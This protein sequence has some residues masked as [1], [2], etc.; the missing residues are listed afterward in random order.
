MSSIRVGSSFP[1]ISYLTTYFDDRYVNITGDTM[2]GSLLF[3]PSVDT[4][5]ILHVKNAAGDTALIVDLVNIGGDFPPY[6]AA[7]GIGTANPINT[8]LLTVSNVANPSVGAQANGMAVVI[9]GGGG[10]YVDDNAGGS[11]KYEVFGS[12]LGFGTTTNTDVYFY[13]N[14]TNRMTITG[15]GFGFGTDNTTPGA[16]LDV[17]GSAIFNETGLNVD[18]RVEGDT[19]ANLLF[20]DASADA[21]GIGTATPTNKLHVAGSGRFTGTYTEATTNSGVHVG[22]VGGTPRLGFFNS[23]AA[24]NWQIDNST[25]TFRWYL[26]GVVHMQLTSTV[27]TANQGM[28]VNETGGNNDI[29]MEGDTATSL[30][31][32]DADVDAVQIGTTVAGAIADFRNGTIVF[33][34]DGADRDI[35]FEGD[36]DV[37]TFYLDAGNNRIGFGT[38]T[39]SQKLHVIG[40]FQVD[41]AT[42]ST[43]G[44]RFRT[45]G[46]NLDVDAGGASLFLS[47]FTTA[48]FGGTQRTY[49]VLEASTENIQLIG[50]VQYR[51]TSF[52][53]VR[54][55]ISG[56]A[57][58]NVTFNEDGASADFRVEG[59]T[60]A[61]LLFVDG[62][63]DFVGIG[64]NA[65]TNK[66]HVTGDTRITGNM[67]IGTTVSSSTLINASK[68]Y[69]DTSGNLFGMTFVAENNA[70]SGTANVAGFKTQV[71]F[72]A[73]FNQGI[74]NDNGL[75]TGMYLL[76]QNAN[77]GNANRLK[78]LVS[79][80]DVL[81]SGTVDT[82]FMNELYAHTTGSG[83]ITNL[84][85]TLMTVW[86][87][88]ANITNVYHFYAKN[89]VETTGAIGTQYGLYIENWT[90]GTT[91]YAIY[92]AGTGSGNAINWTTDTNLYRN[93]ANILKT[94]DK[95]EIGSGLLVEGAT[96]INE[97]GGNFDVRME[98]DTD[99]NL[100]FLDASAD[101]I[102]IGNNA[103]NNKLDVTGTVQMDGLR[104]DQTPTAEV[105]VPTHTFT[106]SL[107][108]TTYR[109]PC[110]V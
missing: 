102:G 94:D 70:A 36:T 30:L 100:F 40:N 38:A 17:R 41:D 3:E 28:V 23:T 75:T 39:P 57:A 86:A 91:N 2:T 47:V 108:G 93:G 87:N 53:T 10:I 99:V 22:I 27:L 95:F 21:V 25:G 62:S 85:G 26:P 9:S 96:T 32:L 19:D 106:L 59:D 20:I 16:L 66:L 105:V 83:V 67:G 48:A 7:I 46:S 92:F 33:N 14:N 42:T 81:S 82:V 11:A 52:G 1:S 50:Q 24:Q 71:Q 37:N 103:P 49:M 68:L 89:G 69:T 35:R 107:S 55:V 73:T 64:N 54:H 51:A 4:A 77:T 5:D 8:K 79:E 56:A 29:R 44:Y 18:F 101:F 98:G 110:L 45:N 80:V 58:G 72:D 74:S 65:P 84:Y 109:V 13:H 34:E 90:A 31:F 88:A 104:I 43:K 97:A 78:G 15:T 61:N 63:A 76:V 60:D 12:I 6:V